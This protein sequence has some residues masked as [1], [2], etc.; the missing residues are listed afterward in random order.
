MLS[1]KRLFIQGAFSSFAGLTC[2][3]AALVSAY[4][5]DLWWGAAMLVL[6][7]VNISVGVLHVLAADYQ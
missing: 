7:L 1:K 2:L 6:G 3:V 5:Q 4:R